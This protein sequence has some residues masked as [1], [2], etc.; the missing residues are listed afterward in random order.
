MLLNYLLNFS[1]RKLHTAGTF[2]LGDGFQANQCLEVIRVG[3][4][5]LCGSW[6]TRCVDVT[7]DFQQQLQTLPV[8]IVQ[9]EL[10]LLQYLPNINQQL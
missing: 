5:C 3:D 7:V 10:Y 6:T 4:D 9:S 8:T 1:A 2:A